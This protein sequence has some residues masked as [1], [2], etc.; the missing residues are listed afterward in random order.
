MA[1]LGTII[2]GVCRPVP[3]QKGEAPSISSL[4]QH[5]ITRSRG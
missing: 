1:R 4:I 3:F 5:V 2:M